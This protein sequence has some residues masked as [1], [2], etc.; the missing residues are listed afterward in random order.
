MNDASDDIGRDAFQ[1]AH[2]FCRDFICL[3]D[4]VES[5]VII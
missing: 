1:N 3:G 4:V 5:F 2:Q